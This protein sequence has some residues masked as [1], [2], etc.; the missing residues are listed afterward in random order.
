VTVTNVSIFPG[1][2]DKNS[3]TATPDLAILKLDS[4]VKNCT[5]IRIAVARPAVRSFVLMPNYSQAGNSSGQ[6]APSDAGINVKRAVVTGAPRFGEDSELY[7][8]A[9]FN[10]EPYRDE[11][12]SS[13]RDPGGGVFNEKG[14]LVGLVAAVAS[15]SFQVSTTILDLTNPRVKAEIE[16]KAA[17]TEAYKG[18]TGHRP[19]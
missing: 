3:R 15:Y 4:P 8:N 1:F 9:E 16:R 2:S 18:T 14:E 10:R 11:P 13:M 17:S 5:P 12:A 6:D 7:F 19:Q